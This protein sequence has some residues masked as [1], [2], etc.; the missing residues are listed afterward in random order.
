MWIEFNGGIEHYFNLDLSDGFG[1]VSK[2]SDEK[3]E[4]HFGI[5]TYYVFATKE[6]AQAKLE[7]LSSINGQND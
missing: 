1:L 6:E 5:G 3:W 4:P 7:E 2:T